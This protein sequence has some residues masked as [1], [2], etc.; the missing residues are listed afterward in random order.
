M[1]EVCDERDA[2]RACR[3]GQD[4]LIGLVLGWL[5]WASGSTLLT[6]ILHIMA[7]FVATVQAAIKVEWMS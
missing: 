6:M 1:H 3:L 7:N 2:R 4:D 5:H